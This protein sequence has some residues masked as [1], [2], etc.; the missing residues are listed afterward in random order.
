M[1]HRGRDRSVCLSLVLCLLGAGA[2]RWAEATEIKG[3]QKI[4]IAQGFLNTNSTPLWVAKEIGLFRK[5]G[6][7][8]EII[9]IRGGAR[10]VAAMLSGEVALSLVAAS[11]VVGPAAAGNDLVMIMG[12]VNKLPYV[13]VVGPQV[14]RPEELRGKKIGV[15]TFGGAA[16][17]ASYVALDTFGLD[18]K[19]D[20]ITL[21][22]LGTEPERIA[23]LMS[24]SIDAAMLGAEFLPRLPMPPY[25]VLLDLRTAGIPWQH[26]GLV[27]SRRLLRSQPQLVEGAVRALAEGMAY[28]LDPKNKESV[29]KI[30]TQYLK[31]ENPEQKEESYQEAVGTLAW[32]PI[33]TVEGAASL[34]NLIVRLQIN[35]GAE[36][37]T[38]L[39]IVDP[40]LMAKLDREGFFDTLRKR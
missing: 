11:Q 23:A 14:G 4:V 25:R 31:L 38:P 5:Y 3:P 20:Q 2:G 12:F 29:V 16:Y 21:L 37:L 34:L 18:P 32:K 7:E 13:F 30:L 1:R 22:Q 24:G 26:T 19:R 27:V 10:V 33:P 28:V 36:K 40:S 6:L 35:P 9:F 8:P 17:V 39:D 15:A